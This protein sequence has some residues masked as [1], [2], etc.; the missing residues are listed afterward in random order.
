MNKKIDPKS[1]EFDCKNSHNK[2][3]QSKKKTK[4]H[5]VI[6]IKNAKDSTSLIN[7]LDET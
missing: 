2:S 4:A 7:S 5:K 1:N 3:N 6:K